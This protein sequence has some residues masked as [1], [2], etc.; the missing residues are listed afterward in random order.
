MERAF[1]GG[2]VGEDERLLLK[3][4]KDAD[5]AP[6]RVWRRGRGLLLRRSGR[7]G[8]LLWSR[9]P[10]LGKGRGAEER[11]KRRRPEDL[12]KEGATPAA[13]SAAGIPVV[14]ED[15]TRRFY[16]RRSGAKRPSLQSDRDDSFSLLQNTMVG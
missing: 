1:G 3:R 4:K 8:E 10:L 9:L 7:F 15:R 12:L 13:L 16:V 6:E 11:A 14:L 2:E 5:A